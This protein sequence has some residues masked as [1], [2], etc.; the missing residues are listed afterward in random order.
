MLIQKNNSSKPLFYFH[1]RISLSSRRHFQLL[2]Q[3]RLFYYF[4]FTTV[5]TYRYLFNSITVIFVF[6]FL[7][8][9]FNSFIYTFPNSSMFYAKHRSTEHRKI[10]KIAEIWNGNYPFYAFKNIKVIVLILTCSMIIHNV[11]LYFN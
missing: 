7:S 1:I 10:I 8:L 11:I 4:L 3:T 9:Y 5:L 2:I 6:L